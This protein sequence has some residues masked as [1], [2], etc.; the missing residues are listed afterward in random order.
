MLIYLALLL[1]M[2]SVFPLKLLPIN[3]EFQCTPLQ[4][5]PTF[6]QTIGYQCQ[7]SLYC[8]DLIH[9]SCKHL[10]E[11]CTYNC[12][13]FQGNMIEGCLPD[14]RIKKFSDKLK[15]GLVY[16]IESFMVT[17]ARTMYRTVEYPHRIRIALQTNWQKSIQNL[18]V[19]LCMCTAQSHLMS[20][21][22][23]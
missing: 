10:H 5:L 6:F 3:A 8:D 19:S 7:V 21:Q 4:W 14:N 2:C 12:F 22:N 17:A 1:L 11:M 15:E 16:K 23:V 18:K 20:S 9:K 13:L